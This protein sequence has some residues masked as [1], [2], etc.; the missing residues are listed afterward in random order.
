MENSRIC[1]IYNVNFHRASYAKRLRSEKH[2]ENEKQMEM[3]TPEWLFLDEKAHIKP[4][5]FT[6]L[7]Y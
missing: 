5:K 6:S 1:E 7:K 3:V 2:L 4:K